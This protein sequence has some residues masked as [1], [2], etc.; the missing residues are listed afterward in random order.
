MELADTAD[1]IYRDTYAT[2]I[3][4]R[5]YISI[6]RGTKKRKTKFNNKMQQEKK[7]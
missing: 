6:C 4:I 7:E 2:M 1:G 3:D 5:R